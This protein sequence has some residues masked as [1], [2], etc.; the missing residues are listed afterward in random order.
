[1]NPVGMP[2]GGSGRQARSS[3]V[4]DPDGGTVKVDFDDRTLAAWI[5]ALAYTANSPS[6]LYV[7]PEPAMPAA[8]APSDHEVVG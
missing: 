2:D 1:M 5:D 7:V 8:S 3:Q 6:G 4:A